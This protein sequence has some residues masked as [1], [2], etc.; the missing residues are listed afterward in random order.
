MAD[1]RTDNDVLLSLGYDTKPA[2]EGLQESKADLVRYKGVVAALEDELRKIRLRLQTEYSREHRKQ[3]EERIAQIRTEL[4][5]NISALGRLRGV[6]RDA[7]RERIAELRAELAEQK[8]FVKTAADQAR[9]AER[10]V[11]AAAEARANASRASAAAGIFREQ[12]RASGEIPSLSDALQGGLAQLSPALGNILTQLGKLTPAAEAGSAGLAGVGGS[13]ALAAGAVIGLLAA[14]GGVAFKLANIQVET[15]KWA[16]D[17]D[18]AA[19][20]AGVTVQEMQH[21]DFI[22]RTVGATAEDLVTATRALSKNIVENAELFRQLG[23]TTR[24]ADG[25]LRNT[26][27]VLIDISRAFQEIPDP[28]QRVVVATELLGRSGQRLIPFLNLGPAKLRELADV[29]RRLAPDI[30]ALSKGYEK[31]EVASLK[32]EAANKKLF[33]TLLGTE[34]PLASIKEFWAG[35]ANSIADAAAEAKK[36]N[37]VAPGAPG[38]QGGV[39]GNAVFTG[40]PRPAVPGLPPGFKVSAPGLTIEPSNVRDARKALAAAEEDAKRKTDSELARLA[41]VRAEI[42]KLRADAKRLVGDALAENL[43]RQKDLVTERGQIEKALRDNA[44]HNLERL[45]EAQR[46]ENELLA[47]QEKILSD[48]AIKG[49]VTDEAQ[50]HAIAQRLEKVKEELAAQRDLQQIHRDNAENAQLSAKARAKEQASLNES[51]RATNKLLKEQGDLTKAQ[52][53][54]IGRIIRGLPLQRASSGSLK[55]SLPVS[56]RDFDA[57]LALLRVREAQ[58]GTQGGKLLK[59]ELAVRQALNNELITQIKLRLSEGTATESQRQKL[60]KLVSELKQNRDAITKIKG[61]IFSQSGLGQFVNTFRAFSDIVG[62][63]SAGLN[64]TLSQLFAVAEGFGVIA[65]Q[66]RLLGGGTQDSSGKVTGGSVFSGLGNLFRRGSGLSGGQRLSGLLGLIGGGIGGGQLIAQL[67][68]GGFSGPGRGALTGGV[69]GLGGLAGFTAIAAA[70]GGF[71]VSAALAALFTNPLTAVI[72]GAAAGLGALF[73]AQRKKT[74]NIAKQ[75]REEIK[76]TLAA[77]NEGRSNLK[78]TIAALER[79]RAAAIARLSGK[80]G[81]S[82]ELQP[83]LDELDKQLNDLR[84]RQKQILDDFRSKTSIFSVPEGARDAAEA[85]AA[86]ARELKNAADAGATAADQIAFLN[87]SLTDLKNKIGRDLRDEEL[88]AI[89]LLKQQIDLQQQRADIEKQAADAELAVRRRSGLDRAL[90][91]AQQAALEIRAIREKRDE[92][93]KQIDE[94]QRLLSAELEGKAELF[95]L[96]LKSLDITAQRT[97]LIDR[98]VELTR[99]MTAEL[100]AQI[101]AQQDFFRDLAAGRIPALPAGLLPT[102]FNFPGGGI[103][104]LQPG[105]VQITVTGGAGGGV[106]HIRRAVEDA[107]IAIEARRRNGLAS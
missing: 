3:A 89:D 61:E 82:K 67:L 87:G 7:T 43:K 4:A 75:V 86:I 71:P 58:S 31:Y 9:E 81:G 23:I 60:E 22:G 1:S 55:P 11:R 21:F 19:Q 18:N 45:H 13:A 84:A 70:A 99:Q 77:F 26:F 83:I 32:V 73:G 56:T 50:L 88:D 78:E 40:P 79:E 24:N 72:G 53:D 10:L 91:P 8:Q 104:Q 35:I 57:E 95:G 17:L 107:F 27:D 49:A 92:Q 48:I 59:E 51:I 36:F 2:K 12:G 28:A 14:I 66:L 90:T 103:F 101:R 44:I 64:K 16:Q 47:E 97:A 34:S 25:G 33:T 74:R 76:D 6:Q 62:K 98:Q 39:G 52:F 29:S 102:G 54:E 63:F 20:S 96:D 15:G 65:N 94:Q 37:A 85:I 38:Q 46:T 30:E 42:E 100:V 5:Q 69:L 41:K 80:K 106:D 93:L 68:S 105:A